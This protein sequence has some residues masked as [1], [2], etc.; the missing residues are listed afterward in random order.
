VKGF[1]PDCHGLLVGPGD[2]VAAE[3]GEI[4]AEV[5][6]HYGLEAPVFAAVLPLD[7]ILRLTPEA[8]RYRAL[9]R[10][11]SVQRD[12]AFVVGRERALS[13]A[14]IQAAIAAEAGPL[15]RHVMLF[16]VFTLEDGRRSLAWRLTFQAD[17]RTLR[18]DEVNEI[19]DRVA[20][21]VEREFDV[22]WRSA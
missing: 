16:D 5:R 11:P 2:V 4:A 14:E 19:Q 10:Y 1:E 3:F 20:R 7:E 6:A 18:D 15:L 9:P 22:T 17:D 8:V 13:A 21:R 12:L